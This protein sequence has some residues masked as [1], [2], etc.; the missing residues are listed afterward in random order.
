MAMFCV[1]Y[2]IIRNHKECGGVLYSLM[3]TTLASAL[4]IG[5]RLFGSSKKLVPELS[6]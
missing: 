4:D 5:L 3:G 6:S 2:Q 1:S